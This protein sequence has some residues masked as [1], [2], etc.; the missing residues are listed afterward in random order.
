MVADDHLQSSRFISYTV[1]CPPVRRHHSCGHR[2]DGGNFIVLQ[3]SFSDLPLCFMDRESLNLSFWSLLLPTNAALTKFYR[4]GDSILRELVRPLFMDR[5][6]LNLGFWYLVLLLSAPMKFY[7]WDFI[8]RENVPCLLGRTRLNLFFWYWEPDKHYSPKDLILSEGLCL[9]IRSSGNWTDC[10]ESV[11]CS[12]AVVGTGS[13]MDLTY[14]TSWS[15]KLRWSLCQNG[16][17][18]DKLRDIF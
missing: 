10:G 3:I 2:G 11:K 14:T 6:T 5:M 8:L 18:T 9:V 17:D 7:R 1:H 12:R 13:R 16:C 4:L 15:C